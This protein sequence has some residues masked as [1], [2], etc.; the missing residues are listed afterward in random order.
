MYKKE[1]TVIGMAF[2]IGFAAET[3][4]EE[5]NEVMSAARKAQAEPRKSVVQVYF[6]ERGRE[7]AYY[8]DMFDLKCGDLVYVEG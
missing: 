4:A 1:G 2:K 8:N 6:P 7:Y 3:P 5:T